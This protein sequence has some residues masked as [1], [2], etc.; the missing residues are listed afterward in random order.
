[1]RN[2]QDTRDLIIS[3]ALPIFN[4]KGYRSTSLSD[5]TNATGM[6]KGAI[7]GNFENKDALALAS[8]DRAMARI[9]DELTLS[10][11]SGKDAPEK[12][13]AI[14][15]YYEKYI[16]NPPIDG[17]CPIINTSVEAD[18][19]YPLL[20]TKA[21]RMIALIRGSLIK[22]IN[23][24]II[25]RQI[26]PKTNV[27]QFASVFYSSIQGALIISRVEGHQDNYQ[28]I[29]QSLTSQINDITFIK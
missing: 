4:R 12:L 26:K 22:I 14:L 6:T 27:E 21:I 2:S 11:K 9:T 17:G 10:I 18:D 23:R 13:K 3:K 29:K 24:G 5:I 15:D 16:D 25:E 8:F 20:R 19:E 7:Y 1:M 28:L